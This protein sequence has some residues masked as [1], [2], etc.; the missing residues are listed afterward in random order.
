MT[1]ENNDERAIPLKPV[2]NKFVTCDGEFLCDHWCGQDIL[3]RGDKVGV[4]YRGDS[5]GLDDDG[6]SDKRDGNR[7]IA[8]ACNAR[9][10]NGGRGL[11]QEDGRTPRVC[12]REQGRFEDPGSRQ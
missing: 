9:N 11:P 8:G 4:K 10:E 12:F 7:A 3:V 5:P 6:L 1:Q 2:G